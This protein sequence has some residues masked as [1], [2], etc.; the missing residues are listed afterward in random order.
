MGVSPTRYSGG[1]YIGAG[2]DSVSVILVE[3]DWDLRFVAG[4][5][6]PVVGIV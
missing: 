5:R 1:R 6:P 4:N 2:I 3:A